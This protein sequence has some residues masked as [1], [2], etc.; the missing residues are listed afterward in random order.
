MIYFSN[1]QMERIKLI[2][3]FYSL[4]PAEDLKE[5][6]E[7]EEVILRLKGQ[8][9]QSPGILLSI[10]GELNMIDS[11]IQQL[12][13]K[14][15]QLESTITAIKTDMQALLRALNVTVFAPSPAANPDFMNLKNK[16]N[17]W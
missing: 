2:D 16:N 9:H 5:A 1:D 10:S 12:E 6:A 8:N 14:N 3:K 4:I 15:Q 13:M 11:R 17:I 7:K